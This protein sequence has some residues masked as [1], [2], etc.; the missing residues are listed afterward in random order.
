MQAPVFERAS[1]MVALQEAEVEDVVAAVGFIKSQPFVDPQRI[2]VSGCS[3]GGIQT[4]LT[5]ER[6]LGVK[7]LVPFSP[8]AMSWYLNM[9]LRDRLS[10]AVDNAREPVFLLQ[11][12]NDY[13]L[14]PIELLTKEAEKKHKDFQSK[15]YPAFG[16]TAQDGHWGFCSRGTDIWGTDVLSFLAAKMKSQ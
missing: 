1:K 12:E 13:S 8:G 6:D 7:A 14:G 4:L 2:A 3:Y 16:H 10:K 11:A 5:G 15:R 9:P